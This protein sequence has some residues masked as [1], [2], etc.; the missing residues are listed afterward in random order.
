MPG[1]YRVRECDTKTRDGARAD[2]GR[3]EA[4]MVHRC[5]QDLVRYGSS[6][7]TLERSP[8]SGTYVVRPLTVSDLRSGR[9]KVAREP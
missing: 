1:S 2:E 8:Q 3:S 7:M 9:G 5:F 6:S 4:V